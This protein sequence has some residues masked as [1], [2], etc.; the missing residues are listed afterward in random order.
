MQ[1]KDRMETKARTETKMQFRLENGV[2]AVFD[3]QVLPYLKEKDQEVL[4]IAS[5]VVDDP[6]RYLKEL[7][8]ELKDCLLAIGGKESAPLLGVDPDSC[9]MPFLDLRHLDAPIKFTL[10]D[11]SKLPEWTT[12]KRNG[13]GSG[14]RIIVESL[15]GPPYLQGDHKAVDPKGALDFAV[16]AILRDSVWVTAALAFLSPRYSWSKLY[17]AEKGSAWIYQQVL[18]GTRRF[19]MSEDTR[20]YGES[21]TVYRAS[22]SVQIRALKEMSEKSNSIAIGG[23]N[24]TILRPGMGVVIDKPL[25][26]HPQDAALEVMYGTITAVDPF[27]D[28][29]TCRILLDRDNLPA[30]VLDNLGPNEL[31]QTNLLCNI[32]FRWIAGTFRLMPPQL[33][34]AEC[35]P[36]GSENQMAN[37]FLGRI[38]VCDMQILLDEEIADYDDEI[39]VSFEIFAK[40]LQGQLRLTLSRLKPF[41]AQAA[42]AYLHRQNELEGGISPPALAYRGLLGHDLFNFALQK[43]AHAKSAQNQHSFRPNM[44]GRAL[45]ELVYLTLKP[46]EYDI[47]FRHGDL[48]VEVQNLDALTPVFGLSP[49]RFDLRREGFGV[50][51]F[52]GPFVFK[53]SQFDTLEPWGPL[54][55]SVSISVGSFTE[56]CR[57]GA[58]VIKSS[59]RHPEALRGSG[60]KAP[61]E[62]KARASKASSET[63]RAKQALRAQAQ[64]EARRQR[65]DNRNVGSAPLASGSGS[66]SSSEVPMGLAS[67]SSSAEE[68]PNV[69]AAEQGDPGHRPGESL[70]AAP[71]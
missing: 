62:K 68:V 44:P 7:S 66:E 71:A 17:M 49:S 57:M 70:A 12:G 25:F 69:V 43:A 31:V 4:Q 51:Q 22:A 54:E 42:L 60:I 46:G 52:H 37:K 2:Y 47:A 36:Q 19:G 21:G 48:M 13:K 26:E 6:S 58:D 10:L 24:R 9:S 33:F 45:M 61:T 41:P 53:W 11:I 1:F 18:N 63:G 50:I 65:H 29:I 39:M 30:Y 59:K 34:N 28:N 23:P 20:T 55:G 5:C 16:S 40:L 56:Y 38:V 35:I 15:L 14:D 67:R 27:S 32:P 8:P 3:E 64:A